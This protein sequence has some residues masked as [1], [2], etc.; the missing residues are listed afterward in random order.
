MPPA[1]ARI[2]VV[3]DHPI[4]RWGL[5]K[6]FAAEDDLAVAG[7][8]ATA[9]E[10][11]QLMGAETFDLV[12]LDIGLKQGSGLDLIGQIRAQYDDLPVLVLSMY[13][14]RFY[15]ERVLRA[16]AQ[17]FVTK[18]GDPRAV[19]EAIR[20]VLGGDLYVSD[21]LADELVLRAVEGPD[22]GGPA[23]EHLSDREAEV[24]RFIGGGLTTREI[25][26]ELNLS[27]KTI[28]SY[29]ANVKR[30]LGLKSGAELAR[31][32]YDWSSR[33]MGVEAG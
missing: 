26:G 19:V 12:L 1:P 6:L 31:F 7:E 13:Q 18:Q 15:A 16:G 32:A 27:V 21:A 2:L 4:V 29:R 30:K 23:V 9:D 3:D 33:S 14:E 24:V 25:A 8:A 11:L 22:G 17:G 5:D 28:E 10:A 20:R